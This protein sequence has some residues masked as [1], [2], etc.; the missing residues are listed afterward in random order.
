MLAGQLDEIALIEQRRLEGPVLGRQLRDLRRTQGT[1]PVH[2]LGLEDLLDARRGQHAAVAH[3]GYFGD[4]E[5]LLELA[6]LR[7][8]R[9]GVGGVALEHLHRDRAA[10]G[11]AHQAEDDLRIVALAVARVAPR[12][13]LAAA[14]GQPGRSEVVQHQ[15]GA[16]EVLARQAPLDGGLRLVQ[17]VQRPV[18]VVRAALAHA[19]HPAQR[20]GGRL[21]AQRAVRGQL[22]GGLEHARHQHGLQQ[23]LQLLGG[24]A[25]PGRRARAARGAEDGGHVAMGQRTLDNE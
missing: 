20:G 25:E 4:A 13:Q 1:D 16:R 14:P 19:Q 17:P 18:Q 11:G 10:L 24:R 7:S 2:A 15:G 12:S 21:V 5:A 22:G 23:R 3:P 8:H 9:G 6:H